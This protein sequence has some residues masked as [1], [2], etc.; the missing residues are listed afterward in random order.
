MSL[1]LAELLTNATVAQTIQLGIEYDPK[2]P[3][4]SGSPDKASQEIIIIIKYA[5]TKPK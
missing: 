3:F 2:P 5:Y 4:N 1:K